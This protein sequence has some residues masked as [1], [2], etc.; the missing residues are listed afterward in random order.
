MMPSEMAYRKEFGSWGRALLECGFEVKKPYPSDNCKRA[1]SQAKKG[2]TG[3]LS[4]VW[5]GGRYIDKNGY[6]FVW[7]TEKQ[8]YEREHRKIMME[9]LGRPLYAYED[10]HHVNGCKHDNRIENLILMS[11]SGHTRLHEKQGDH[12]HKRRKVMNC[13]F[14]NCHNETSGKYSLCR[15]HYKLQWQRLKCGII[16]SILDFREIK[17]THTDDTKKKL[18][19][20]AKRQPRKNGRFCNIHDNPELLEDE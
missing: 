18:S 11:K 20:L 3:I 5:K 1:V 6:A 16:D 10:I 12:N 2:K 8:K 17:H 19:E 14:P 15:K 7:N 9:Y 13:I 4:P